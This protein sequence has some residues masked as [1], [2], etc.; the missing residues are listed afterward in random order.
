MIMCAYS[1]CWTEG[2]RLKE[3]PAE[4]EELQPSDFSL[5]T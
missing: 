4:D 1:G 5:A 2:R 3:D